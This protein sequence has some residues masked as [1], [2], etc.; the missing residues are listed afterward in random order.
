MLIPFT[1]ERAALVLQGLVCIFLLGKLA[2]VST[3]ARVDL[4]ELQVRCD[5][6]CK[7]ES[8]PLLLPPTTR[9]PTQWVEIIK[10]KQTPAPLPL[11]PP[12]ATAGGGGAPILRCVPTNTLAPKATPPQAGLLCPSPTSPHKSIQIMPASIPPSALDSLFW[13]TIENNLQLNLHNPQV[14]K[15]IS[16]SIN[17]YK[18]WE[19][20]IVQA[21]EQAVKLYP[22]RAVVDIGA[23][24]GYFSLIALGKLNVPRV[25]SFEP[26]NYNVRQIERTM[27]RNKL[28]SNRW[29]VYQ[30]AVGSVAGLVVSLRTPDA[31]NNAGNH[32]I[33]ASS[34][35][36][37]GKVYGDDFVHTVRLDQ[38][39][40][41]DISF[42]KIDVEGWEGF[43][44][45]GA[46][47]L[48]RKRKVYRVLIEYTDVK[49]SGCNVQKM[50][51]WFKDMGYELTNSSGGKDVGRDVNI[52]WTLKRVA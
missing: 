16:G 44:F 24:I 14:D 36:V 52:M 32:K 15:Y 46:S 30:N 27:K 18:R 47:E 38:V 23:N 40:D 45:D 5:V 9:V 10:P 20:T 7:C 19:Y 8:A 49:T 29:K 22:Q 33:V 4:K 39:V 3:R 2:E 12:P 50:F 48:F 34:G 26:M 17:A 42:M 13:A 31:R 43:V 51:Q 41:E 21:M 37:D 28:D 25:Y 35:T 11:P 1:W 6:A